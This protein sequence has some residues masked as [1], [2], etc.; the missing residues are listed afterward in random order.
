MNTNDVNRVM[1]RQILATKR[2]CYAISRQIGRWS[3]GEMLSEKRWCR[4]LRSRHWTCIWSEASV[5][6]GGIIISEAQ[7]DIPAAREGR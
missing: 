1:R 7:Q 6:F 2:E 5:A 4:N 3:D